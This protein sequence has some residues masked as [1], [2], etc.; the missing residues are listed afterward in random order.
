MKNPAFLNMLRAPKIMFAKGTVIRDG[1]PFNLN[2][3]NYSPED[4]EKII[5]SLQ[6]YE[7]RLLK[8]PGNSEGMHWIHLPDTVLFYSQR[9]FNL[10]YDTFISR[11]NICHIGEFYRDSISFAT[12]IVERDD[13]DRPTRQAVRIVALPQPNY[14]ALMGKG[15]LDVYKLEKIDY[16]ENE[17][18]LWMLTVKSPNGS[19]VCD[20]GLTSFNRTEDGKGT[21]VSFLAC[22]NF[23]VPPL[24]ALSRIDKWT[25]FKNTV[26]EQAYRDFCNTMMQNI[27]DR[28]DGRDFRVGRSGSRLQAV[29]PR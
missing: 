7:Q 27:Q 11:V 17:Q 4:Y 25:W 12:E 8:V 9:V 13:L 6:E 18:R 22:Q 26:T 24:M 21:I 20:D 23:P 29:L 3:D 15:N 1:Y 28:Y 10:P 19:A 16:S 2:L 14:A 5:P